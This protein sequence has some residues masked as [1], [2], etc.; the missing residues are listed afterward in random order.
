MTPTEAVK[1]IEQALNAATLKGVYTLADTNQIL[2]ALNVV[3]NL[4]PVE[5][6]KL[7]VAE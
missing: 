6:L 4:I 7:E 2:V 5:E 3:H 1:T